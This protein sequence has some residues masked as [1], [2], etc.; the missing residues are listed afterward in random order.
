MFSFLGKKKLR[1]EHVAKVFV[2]TINELAEKSFPAI[3][4]LLN[5]APELEKSPNIN[6]AN[7]EW[8][9]FIVFSANLYNLKFYFQA[10]QLNRMRIMVIDEFIE[11][12]TGRD[13]DLSLEHINL[14]E[15]FI[16][17]LEKKYADLPKS[18]ALAIFN[19][20]GLN[21]CQLSHFQ[22]L[23]EPS[24]IIIKSIE[25]VT[26]N[27]LWNWNDFLEKYKLVG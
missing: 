23:N 20:Y 5:E 27:F 21:T 14:Y 9:L 24:P 26:R 15:D 11:S 8:F 25:E 4:D 16:K 2:G 10:D 6:K 17:G 19:K 12:L 18:M 7:L 22:K 1:E 3:A 13:H